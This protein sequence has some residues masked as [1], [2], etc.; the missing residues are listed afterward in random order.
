MRWS[1]GRPEKHEAGREN[2]EMY[3]YAVKR[4]ERKRA[5]V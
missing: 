4:D 5:A 3:V 2:E 1:A